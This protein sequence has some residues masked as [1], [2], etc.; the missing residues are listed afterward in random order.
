MKKKTVGQPEQVGQSKIKVLLVEDH[1]ATL[2][3]LKAELNEEQD[4]EVAGTATTSSE[5]LSLAQALNPDIILL[6]LHLPDSTGPKSL[7]ET[8]CR[9]GKAKVIV[10]SGDTRAAILQIVLQ[11]GVAGYLLKS[12]PLSLVAH[13]IREVMGGNAPV[14]SSELAKSKH[15]HL[16]S[17]ERHLLTLLAR[18]LKYQDIAAQRFTAPET[19]RKQVEA[20]LTKLKLDSRES[21]IAWAVDSG[22]GKLEPE[23]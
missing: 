20:L 1:E 17:T 15:P 5:A 22:Y 4:I 2:K 7:S 18:G 6:D 8:F 11:T 23:I 3:G 21:L 14:I 16:T 12:E 19:V 13:A 10:F 9:L